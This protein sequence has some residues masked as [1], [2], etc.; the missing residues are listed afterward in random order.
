MKERE[1]LKERIGKILDLPQ[2]LSG[3]SVIIT[4]KGNEEISV[5][6]CRA[7]IEYTQE[8]IRVN[9]KRSMLTIKGKNMVIKEVT[10]EYVL[11]EGWIIGTEYDM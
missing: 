11:I 5:E 10:N 7:I 4:I 1:P 6:G 3:D 8:C 9:T 2:E